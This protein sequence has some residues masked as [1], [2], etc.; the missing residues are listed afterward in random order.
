MDAV[1][2]RHPCCRR[3][4]VFLLLVAA[5]AYLVVESA[6]TPNQCLTD[7]PEVHPKRGLYYEGKSRNITLEVSSRV[8]HQLITNVFQIFLKEVLGYP[9]VQMVN[10]ENYEVESILYGLSGSPEE[11]NDTVPQTMVNLEVWVNSSFDVNQVL[12]WRHVKECGNVAPPLRFGWFIPSEL[13]NPLR[14][15]PSQPNGEIH[16][17]VFKK[18]SHASVFDINSDFF[19][20]YIREYTFRNKSNNEFHCNDPKICMNGVHVPDRCRKGEKCALLLAPDYDS[21][22]FL[23]E[24]IEDLKVYVKVAWLGPH[25]QHVLAQLKSVYKRIN[26]RTNSIIFLSWYLSEI[27][28]DG[29]NFLAVSFDRC[30]VLDPKSVGCKYEMTRLV[31]FTWSKLEKHAEIAMLAINNLKF[32]ETE[33]KSLLD[34]YSSRHDQL[35]MAEIACEWIRK[36]NDAIDLWI[37]SD[38][39]KSE[40]HIGGIFP[41]TG[42]SYVGNGIL[43]AALMARDAV[44]NNAT[45]LRD[46]RLKLI[47]TNGQCEA[48]KVMKAFIDFL[49]QNYEHLAGVLGPACSDTVEPLAGVSKHYRTLV[50][51]YSAEG[52]SFSDREKYPYFFRTIGENKQYKYVYLQLFKKF[53]WKRVAALTEDGQ[54]YT[55]YISQMQDMVEKEGISFIT[56]TK[57]PKERESYAM[58]RYLEDLKRKRARIIIA[59]IYDEVARSVMCDAYH[60]EMTAKQGYVW[61]L[62]SWLNATWYNTTYFNEIHKENISCSVENMTDAINGYFSLS[63]AFFAPN[64]SIM[65]ENI[66]VGEWRERYAKN[67][68]ILGASNYA[69]FAYDAVWVY[70]LALNKLVED[71]P[72]AISNLHSPET[73]EKFVELVKATDFYGV[74][75]RIKFRGGPS[76]FSI[77][78]IWQWLNHELKLVGTFSPNI[79]NDKPEIYGGQLD[80]K[81]NSIV[82]F[83]KNNRKPDDGTLPPSVCALSGVA[84]FLGVECEMAIIILNLIV[85]TILV[86]VLIAAVFVIKKRY[87][88]KVQITQ[89]YMKS[90]GID[91]LSA[92][93]IAGL[94]KWEIARESVVINRKLGEGAFGT[95]YGGE[96][97]F[98]DSGWLAVAVKTLK[99]GSTTEEKLDFLSEAEVMKRFEHKNIVKLL[100]VCTK[101]EP[102]YT[103]MEFMLYGDLKTYLLARRHLVKDKMSDES[104][105]VSPKRLTSMAL[106]VARG[107]SYLAELKY[108]HRD[109]ASRNCLVNAQRVVKLGDFGMTRPMFENDYY[110]FNRKGMLPVRWMAPESLTLGVFTAASDVWSYGILLYEIITFGSFPFQGLSNNQVLEHVKAGNTLT[111]PQGIKPQLEGLLKSCWNQ[112]NKLRPTSSEIV[113]FLANNPRLLMP[114]LDIPLSSVQ[115]EDTGQLEMHLPEQFRKCSLSLNNTLSTK[116]K[117]NGDLT[118]TTTPSSKINGLRHNNSDGGTVSIPIDKCC[119]R[120]P[121]LGPSSRSDSFLRLGKY[122]SVQYNRTDSSVSE[123]DDHN[124]YCNHNPPN[125]HAITQL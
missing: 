95:V 111:I 63:S 24:H 27:V 19:E 89:R 60:L 125:G 18:P 11:L 90:L 124:D 119:L 41:L 87:D 123:G 26:T 25:L 98:P 52:A 32:N 33:Y 82:W 38:R 110:K 56:N 93:N 105:E 114:C 70:A 2:Y 59:D 117:T 104:D 10:K 36:H 76:R 6:A 108:V 7:R 51:S 54:K 121:L 79:S 61:F 13:S 62:P 112:D 5:L 92:S 4:S 80:I 44:N 42:S 86:T 57:F 23:I 103:V 85:A 66:T 94:D 1:I 28:S 122:V 97:N 40:I 35:S 109:V 71:N 29:R 78:N 115:M 83:T 69:G 101:N 16:W 64:D 113:E 14:Q 30:D 47:A 99:V 43:T 58:I 20:K 81:P 106:D 39:G 75:G 34:L 48:D 96:A 15:I 74:S 68:S 37:P 72:M 49:I 84:Y 21:T 3:S 118:A 17:S 45:I 22:S 91:L 100:G 120:E 107:L 53:G 55:E 50:I 46:Y 77:V 65:Q 8:S 31:K 102:V 88:K 9:N 12:S 116:V 67:S 73:T